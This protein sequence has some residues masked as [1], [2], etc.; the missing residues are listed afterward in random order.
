[1]PDFRPLPHRPLPGAVRPQDGPRLKRLRA[2]LRRRWARRALRQWLFVAMA[3]ASL[4]TAV[5]VVVLFFVVPNDTATHR[6]LERIALAWIALG[7]FLLAIFALWRLDR[8]RRA[9]RAVRI[10]LSDVERRMAALQAP[11]KPGRRMPAWRTLSP[12]DPD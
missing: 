2:R 7:S 9:T 3:F 4:A 6:L 8:T 12:P 10:R 5:T 1:M 11:N